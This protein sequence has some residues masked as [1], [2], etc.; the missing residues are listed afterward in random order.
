MMPGLPRMCWAL[1]LMLLVSTPLTL[2]A[3]SSPTAAFKAY[4]DAAKKKDISG[5]KAVISAAYLKELAKAPVPLE[6]MLEALTEQVPPTLPDTRNETI[7]GD[8]ATLEYLDHDR[9]QWQAMTFVREN[10]GWKLAR[11]SER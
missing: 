3:Q 6:R 1:S 2:S 11:S 8:Q 5:L 4:Y 10:G 7:S 9:K